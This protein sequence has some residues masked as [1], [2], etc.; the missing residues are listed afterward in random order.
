M[1]SIDND[2]PHPDNDIPHPASYTHHFN[3]LKK[4]AIDKTKERLRQDLFFTPFGQS[5]E[6]LETQY[7]WGFRFCY[8]LFYQIDSYIYDVIDYSLLLAINII[9]V[10]FYPL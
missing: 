1:I 7:S 4:R 6:A 3:L 5:E 2:T 8:D 9:V 10:L